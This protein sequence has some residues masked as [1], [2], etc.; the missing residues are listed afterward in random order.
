[1][2]TVRLTQKLIK[3]HVVC[4]FCK[5]NAKAKPQSDKKHVE[6]PEIIIAPQ[7]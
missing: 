5:R 7:K 6:F 1:M 4:T 3:Q 2:F